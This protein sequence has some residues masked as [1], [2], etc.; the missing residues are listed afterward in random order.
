MVEKHKINIQYQCDIKSI[1]R[2]IN[3]GDHPIEIEYRDFK[4]NQDEI[5]ECDVLFTAVDLSTFMNSFDVLKDE[6]EVFGDIKSYTLCACLCE[7]DIEPNYLL[8]NY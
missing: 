8:R 6:K 1:N 2:F 5:A 3:D 4:T 7:W